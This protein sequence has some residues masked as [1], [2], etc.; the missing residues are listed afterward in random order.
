MEFCGTLYLTV[1]TIRNIVIM[2]TDEDNDIE[3]FPKA[4]PTGDKVY[5]LVET[6]TSAIP[7]GQQMLH[8][9]IASPVQ[10]RMESWI[11]Q[12]EEKLIIL[13]ENKKIDLNELKN[14]PE[15]SALL[16]RTIQAAA[17][18]S[19]D[20]QLTNLRNYILNISLK[21]ELSEDEAF[22]FLE[23]IKDF[24]PSHVRVLKFYDSPEDYLD[25]II[26]LQQGTVKGIIKPVGNIPQGQELSY[27]FGYG[28]PE[29]WYNIY[30]IV[31]GKHLIVS[32]DSPIPG[33]PDLTV[34]GQSTEY[35][36]KILSM[37]LEIDE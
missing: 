31:E 8:A 9:L 26:E 28:E 1:R 7:T 37:M 32:L 17:V 25:K 11:K 27:V 35:G 19:Q 13:E 36:K 30:N 5:R 4:E 16:L 18:T 24:T 3:V 20:E 6:V 33:S 14:R 23:V 22:I 34:R 29:Y 15:F 2:T 21:P 10:K 12:T